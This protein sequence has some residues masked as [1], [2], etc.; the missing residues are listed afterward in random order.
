MNKKSYE[1]W[2]DSRGDDVYV[3]YRI[4]P[5]ESQTW[6]Y[7][8]SDPDIEIQTTKIDGEEVELTE[9]EEEIVRDAIYY[10]EAKEG[11]EEYYATH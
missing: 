2:L 10:I 7:P 6:D 9:A 1:V 4:W 3:I 11:E 5:G 8:G